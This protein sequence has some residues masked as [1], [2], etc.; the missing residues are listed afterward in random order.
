M[1]KSLPILLTL[2]LLSGCQSG[3]QIDM[4]Q[5]TEEEKDAV[6][7]LLWLQSADATKDVQQSLERG[8]KRL[9]ALATRGGHLPGVEPDVASKA[10]S[11]CGLRY[12]PGSTDTVT[13]KTHLQLLQAAEGYAADYNRIMIGHC[14]QE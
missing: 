2:L 1:K 9:L 5:V 13:G 14:L 3:G 10:K 7:S 12:L 4:S 6:E 11:I 8:D